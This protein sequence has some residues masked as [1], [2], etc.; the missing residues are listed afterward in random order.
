MNNHVAEIHGTREKFEDA[1]KIVNVFACSYCYENMKKA[2]ELS[3]DVV[4]TKDWH[5]IAVAY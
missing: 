4:I 1:R 5:A 3:S 2:S